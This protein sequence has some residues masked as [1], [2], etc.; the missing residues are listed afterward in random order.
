[1]WRGPGQAAVTGWWLDFRSEVWN[2]DWRHLQLQ[3]Q[4]ISE[5]FKSAILKSFI[6]DFILYHSLFMQQI[7]DQMIYDVL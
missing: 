6:P 1:M 4:K 3:L 7:Y 2:Q 5:I